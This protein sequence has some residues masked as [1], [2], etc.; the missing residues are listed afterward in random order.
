MRFGGASRRFS[1]IL[2]SR[3]EQKATVIRVGDHASIARPL[4]SA[5]LDV[6]DEQRE[7]YRHRERGE[8]G[9]GATPPDRASAYECDQEQRRTKGDEAE[10]AEVAGDRQLALVAKALL[11]VARADVGGDRDDERRQ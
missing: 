11:V 8:H 4:Q 2:N 1:E 6:E 5:V 9:P 10:R 7:R 3:P